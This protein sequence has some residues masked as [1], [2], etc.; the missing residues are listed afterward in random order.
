MNSYPWIINE[1]L[2]GF[3]KGNTR[4]IACRVKHG[5][6]P[7]EYNV[8]MCIETGN[9]RE[10]FFSIKVFLG[11]GALYRR[12]VEI[13]SIRAPVVNDEMIRFH[14][15]L[16]EDWILETVS[17][18]EGPGEKIYVEYIMDPET[19]IPLERGYPE[20]VSRL[21]YELL[22]RDYTWFKDWYFAEGF[23]E[24]S[25]KLQGEKPLTTQHRRRHL[26]KIKNTLT[27]F[28]KEKCSTTNRDSYLDKACKRAEKI[29]RE[30]L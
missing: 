29:L 12:W 11:R 9:V 14:G 23:M 6:F 7:E 25:P 4:L 13:H 10:E 16:Y 8:D 2:K 3:K 22:R 19:L 18:W 27:K 21:G 5:R 30:Y 17:R 15:T 1:L 20:P 24:G 28:T 26:E